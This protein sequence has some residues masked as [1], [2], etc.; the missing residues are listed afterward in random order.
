MKDRSQY[1][2]NYHRKNRERILKRMRA[3][4]KGYVLAHKQEVRE[5]H[6]KWLQ[7][8]K[9]KASRK[10]YCETH[11]EQLREYQRN[12]YRR[13]RG[14]KPDGKKNSSYYEILLKSYGKEKAD[15]LWKINH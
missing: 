12:Y 4:S 2:K 3:Y 6:K 15:K 10:R 8:P 9:G 7:S 5:R 11:R 1:Y 14:L 13:K